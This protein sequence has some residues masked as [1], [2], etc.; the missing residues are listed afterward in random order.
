MSKYE[1]IRLKTLKL[2]RQECTDMLEGIG[3]ECTE[4]GCENYSLYTLQRAVAHF[5]IEGDLSIDD[6][7]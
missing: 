5:I 7:C 3:F 2:T 6:I 4:A 1:S